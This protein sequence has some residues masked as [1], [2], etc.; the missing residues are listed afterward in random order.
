MHL[1]DFGSCTRAPTYSTSNGATSDDALLH[2]GAPARGPI[3]TL[4]FASVAADECDERSCATP[5]QP[6]DD[7][8]SLAY[9]LAF[10]A[11]GR[12]PWHS[13]PADAMASTK[14]ELLL[15]SGSGT[16]AA[17]TEGVGCAMATA[18]LEALYAEV[19]R[20]QGE[21][22]GGSSASVDYETCLAAFARM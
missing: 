9:T 13:Q 8:E 10:L 4:L 15:A 22:E 11:A 19:R 12:L 14:R 18:A 20:C 6:V 3:G 2:E 7:I 21:E 17:L 1:T 5:T 16:A